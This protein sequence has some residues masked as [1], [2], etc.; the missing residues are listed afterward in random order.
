[1]PGLTLAQGRMFGALYESILFGINLVLLCAVIYVYLKEKKTTWQQRMRLGAAL[2][3]FMMCAAHLAAVMRGL[4]LAFFVST[5]PPDVFYLDHTQP[6]DLTQKAV[7][8]V[9]T[10]FADGLAFI[11]FDGR[12][13]VVAFPIL[14]LCSTVGLWIALIR[15]Y[16]D[17]APGT[18]LFPHP[19]NQLAVAAFAMS[20]ITNLVITLMIAVRI[21]LTLRRSNSLG[22][23][24]SF[25]KR[26]LAYSVESGLLYPVALLITAIMFATDDNGLE[27]LSGSNT[28]ILGIVPSL[29]ALQL[30]L[31]L[32]A[33]NN[34]TINPGAN[35]RAAV[36]TLQFATD[37]G[38][39]VASADDEIDRSHKLDAIRLDPTKSESVGSRTT[40]GRASDF[41][42]GEGS[43]P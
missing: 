43:D 39:S 6:V 10:F 14:S 19:V 35:S 8:A 21:W 16:H 31:N 13:L 30:R 20:F 18:T 23:S 28:Q 24:T 38:P 40:G 33:Y 34:A 17:S 22:L 12:W 32:S 2:I 9:A 25:Y 11:I 42:H 41:K 5:K 4:Y 27:I 29:L 1:M 37:E 3:V 36:R 15:A 7:Y 26:F